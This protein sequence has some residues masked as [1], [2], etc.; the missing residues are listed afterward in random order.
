MLK[1]KIIPEIKKNI[2]TSVTEEQLKNDPD[3][4]RFT[5]TFDREAFSPI[6]FAE[7]WTEHRVA[8]LTYNKNGKDKW[9]EKYFSKQTVKIDGN[10]VTMELAQKEL[11][12]AD[13]KMREVRKKTETEHQTSIITTNRKLSI[14]MVAIYM[15][16]RWAQ[17][18]FFKYLIKEYNLD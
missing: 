7:L 15:F 11:V 12:F 18:N 17:E 1:T 9:E 2:S 5:M 14:I 3:L 10:K 13:V 8:V 4:P 6:F 16:S